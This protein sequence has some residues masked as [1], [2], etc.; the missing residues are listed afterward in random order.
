MPTT[1]KPLQKSKSVENNL[2]K[3]AQKALGR[4][5]ARKETLS[6][7][8]PQVQTSNANEQRGLVREI[9]IDWETEVW[10]E[11]YGCNVLREQILNI[12][13]NL[14]QEGC[15]LED[16]VL[17]YVNAIKNLYQYFNQP[18][19]N[20]LGDT[21]REYGDTFLIKY[22]SYRKHYE[23][24]DKALGKRYTKIKGVKEAFT[25]TSEGVSVLSS[26]LISQVALYGTA[27][28]K[29]L[30]LP[31]MSIKKENTFAGSESAQENI[32][33]TSKNKEP[34]S[35]YTY[36]TSALLGLQPLASVGLTIAN[37]IDWYF[38]SE[39]DAVIEITGDRLHRAYKEMLLELD[40]ATE[41]IRIIRQ[42][43]NAE[44]DANGQ[45]HFATWL[46]TEKEKKKMI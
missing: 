4:E 18:P 15:E 27:Y 38:N 23:E 45:Q 13:P 39:N 40:H 24:L 17:D 35:W 31:D 14:E 36:A 21:L 2:K 20:R 8:N 5:T 1:K 42:I 32:T 3:P 46:Q 19:Y 10:N 6:A 12:L 9:E 16:T 29:T 33:L 28:G 7:G 44:A 41:L 30:V 37:L 43:P 26:G 34:A 11:M 25:A 22:Q